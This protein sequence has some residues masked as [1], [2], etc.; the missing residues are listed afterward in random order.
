MTEYGDENHLNDQFDAWRKRRADKEAK[1]QADLE[2]SLVENS[3]ENLRRI[4][5]EEVKAEE[6]RRKYLK[7]K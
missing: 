7:R 6:L 4:E 3:D 5:R 1:E 2:K